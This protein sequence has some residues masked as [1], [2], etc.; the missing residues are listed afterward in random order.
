MYSYNA[1]A[2]VIEMYP[3]SFLPYLCVYPCRQFMYHVRVQQ[4]EEHAAGYAAKSAEDRR[5]EP[6]EGHGGKESAGGH[7]V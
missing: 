4:A 6:A 7:H 3:M 2:C 1:K 5:A